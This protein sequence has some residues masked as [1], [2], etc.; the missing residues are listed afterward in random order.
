MKKYL[1]VIANDLR[2]TRR[3][4]TLILLFWVPVLILIVV[5][6]GMPQLITYVPQIGEYQLHIISVFAAMNAIFPGF[7]L[8]FM[9]LDEKDAHLLPIIKVTPVSLSGFLAVRLL[10]MVMLGFTFSF[11]LLLFNG[12]YTFSLFQAIAI[13]FL[14]ALNSPI[15]ILLISTIARNKIEGMTLLKVANLV[16]IIPALTYFIHSP[17]E[18]LLGVFPAFWVYQAV[19]YLNHQLQFYMIF[20]AGIIALS[21]LNGLSFRWSIKK[22]GAYD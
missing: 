7:I 14:C 12:I 15:L 9:L 4:P 3:D 10:F 17:F 1:S 19:D 22:L 6:F 13:A 21:I 11:I 18:Y 16:L 8:S 5:R 2:N 20:F